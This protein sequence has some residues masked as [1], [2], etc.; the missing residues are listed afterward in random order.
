MSVATIYLCAI[1]LIP[2]DTYRGARW[3][4]SEGWVRSS[5]TGEVTGVWWNVL[6]AENGHIAQSLWV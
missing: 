4:A 3:R 5:G 1:T 6:G 2:L